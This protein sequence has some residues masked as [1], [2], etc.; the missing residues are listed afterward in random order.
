MD[1]RLSL[2]QR[3]FLLVE[4]RI[5]KFGIRDSPNILG[6]LSGIRIRDSDS[7]N[8]ESE[9]FKKICY[10]LQNR[11]QT[12]RRTLIILSSQSENTVLLSYLVKHNA[13]K[14]LD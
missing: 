9:T 4:G 8:F 11:K 6:F 13:T 1:T 14:Y 7:A 3:A 5:P 12:S 2:V 10:V